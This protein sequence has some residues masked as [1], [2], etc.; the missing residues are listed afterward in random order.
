[1]DKDFICPRLE[2]WATLFYGKDA[3]VFAKE[4]NGMYIFGTKEQK[5]TLTKAV[6]IFLVAGNLP[7][8]K[9]KKKKE[10]KIVRRRR[11]R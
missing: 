3:K 1:M 7:E 9:T 10:K 11:K 4:K 2:K 5:S 6:A 8:H